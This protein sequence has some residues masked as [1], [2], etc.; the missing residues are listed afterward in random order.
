MARPKKVEESIEEV[1]EE[2]SFPKFTCNVNF[3]NKEYKKGDEWTAEVPEAI[4]PFLE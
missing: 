3:N 2:K 1:S 4:K